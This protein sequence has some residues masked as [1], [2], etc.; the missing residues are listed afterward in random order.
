MKKVNL[1]HLLSFVKAQAL[2]LERK[3]LTGHFAIPMLAFVVIVNYAVLAFMCWNNTKKNIL[4]P[5]I[6]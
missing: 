6:T 1:E 5:N 3:D 4:T 2:T